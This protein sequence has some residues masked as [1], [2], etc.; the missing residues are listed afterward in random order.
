MALLVLA[1]RFIH[2]TWT[3]PLPL[4]LKLTDDARWQLEA[5]Y[6][7]AVAVKELM[8]IWLIGPGGDDGVV[9]VDEPDCPELVLGPPED[10]AFVGAGVFVLPLCGEVPRSLGEVVVS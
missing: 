10:F 7:L 3:L 8:V 4:T 2:V 6:A 1:L 9:P 5:L